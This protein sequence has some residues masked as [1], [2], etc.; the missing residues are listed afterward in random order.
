MGKPPAICR[1]NVLLPGDLLPESFRCAGKHHVSEL[2]GRAGRAGTD[3]QAHAGSAWHCCCRLAL[4][5][6]SPTIVSGHHPAS[7]PARLGRGRL[8]DR[9]GA[10]GLDCLSGRERRRRLAHPS[11]LRR[12]RALA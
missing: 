12:P 5:M 10:G 11:R 6:C 4:P 9:G 3:A 1:R 2:G 8:R 7:Q